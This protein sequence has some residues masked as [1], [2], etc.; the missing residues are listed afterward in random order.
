MVATN[1][2]GVALLA[3]PSLS[4]VAEFPVEGQITALKTFDGLPDT[5]IIGIEQKDP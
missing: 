5:V 1:P 2:S 4:Q 3:L